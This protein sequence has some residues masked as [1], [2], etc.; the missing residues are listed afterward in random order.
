[1]LGS[2]CS[3]CFAA[4]SPLSCSPLQSPPYCTDCHQADPEL[5]HTLNPVSGWFP[6]NSR[7]HTGLTLSVATGKDKEVTL[8]T[9]EVLIPLSLT[10]QNR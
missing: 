7:C 9:L 1:M 3:R 6:A 5:P 4:A 10:H 2:S 8:Q